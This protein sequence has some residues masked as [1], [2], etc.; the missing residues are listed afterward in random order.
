MQWIEEVDGV[1][2]TDEDV[3]IENVEREEPYS[4]I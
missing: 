3:V 2:I 4:V 1:W